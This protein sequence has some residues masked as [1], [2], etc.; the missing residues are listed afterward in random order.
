VNRHA[1]NGG[2]LSGGPFDFTIDGIADYVSGISLDSSEI[3]GTMSTY[4]ITDD[5][6]NILRLPPTLDAVEGINFDG[7]GTGVCLIWHVSYEEGIMGLE[8]GQNT[9]D[10]DGYFG[11]SNSITVTRN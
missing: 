1:I 4:I 6:N 3:N 11:L 8:V 2:T 9:D 10:L 7:A 5:A